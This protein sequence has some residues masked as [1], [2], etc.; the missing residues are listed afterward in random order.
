[1]VRIFFYVIL[2]KIINQLILKKSAKKKKI[3]G[4]HSEVIIL[5]MTVPSLPA[6]PMRTTRIGVQSSPWFLMGLVFYICG[7][8][9]PCTGWVMAGPW[10]VLE[11]RA[12]AL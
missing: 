7:P 5:H 12:K 1:M 8:I 2:R 9:H 10:P 6:L 4:R 11:M 3:A